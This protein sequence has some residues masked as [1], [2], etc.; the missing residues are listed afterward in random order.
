M[1]QF[2]SLGHCWDLTVRLGKPQ[3]GVKTQ[4][5]QR[6]LKAIFSHLCSW[7]EYSLARM[8]IRALCVVVPLCTMSNYI[9]SNSTQQ[10]AGLW[11]LLGLSISEGWPGLQVLKDQL[12]LWSQIQLGTYR[13]V[14]QG[15]VFA[16]LSCPTTNYL[17]GRKQWSAWRTTRCLI[18]QHLLLYSLSLLLI[19]VIH[20]IKGQIVLTYSQTAPIDCNSQLTHQ[21]YF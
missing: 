2:P 9:L 21:G 11:S 13:S 7:S 4:K 17:Q 3:A 16:F 19:N 6:Q 10:A 5:G 12:L 20:Y 18:S 15:S 1:S 8:E 14:L